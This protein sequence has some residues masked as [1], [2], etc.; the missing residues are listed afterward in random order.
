M[1]AKHRQT[2]AA[3]LLVDTLQL[4]PRVDPAQISDGWL[5]EETPA[6]VTLADVEGVPLALQ[7][8]L[9]TLD[10]PLGG[11]AGIRLQAAAKRTIAQSLRG[12]AELESTL[13][14]LDAVN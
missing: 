10:I 8:R 7:R 6:L 3:R 2:R 11:D 14:I 12:D 1:P 13:A 5:R 9:K 4:T